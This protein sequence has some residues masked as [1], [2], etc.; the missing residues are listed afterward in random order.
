M[1]LVGVAVGLLGVLIFGVGIHSYAEGGGFV[2]FTGATVLALALL[3]G[4]V[5]L[6]A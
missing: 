1:I 2:A 6:A 5:Q 4:A 3:V